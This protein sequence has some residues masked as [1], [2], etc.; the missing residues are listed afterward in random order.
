MADWAMHSPPK[1]KNQ[2]ELSY[3]TSAHVKTIYFSPYPF[4]PISKRSKLTILLIS[5]QNN[6][7]MTNLTNLMND[8]VVHKTQ[9]QR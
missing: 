5:S 1:Q 8:S 4:V 2:S 9:D 6:T 3:E 7:N